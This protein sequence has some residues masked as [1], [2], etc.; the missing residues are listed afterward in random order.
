[1]SDFVGDAQM[2]LGGVV[3]QLEPRS[4]LSS[5]FLRGPSVRAVTPTFRHGDDRRDDQEFVVANTSMGVAVSCAGRQ[6]YAAQ[7]AANGGSWF[8][9]K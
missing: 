1:M 8:R 3:H 5:S 4:V 7:C 9:H 2:R 6:A